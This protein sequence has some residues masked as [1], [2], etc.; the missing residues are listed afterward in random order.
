MFK[1]L[2]YFK[3]HR[4]KSLLAPLFKMT[5]AV[6]ELFVPLV[7]ARIIDEGITAGEEQVVYRGCLLLVLLAVL[8]LAAALLA[9]YFASMAAVGF[10]AQVREALFAKVLR[11]PAAE[12]GRLGSNRLITLLSGDIER[13]Q[14]GVNMALRL[15]MR[16]PVVVFGA[17]VMAFITD[18]RG[19][20]STGWIFA[21]AV[22]LLTVAVVLVM[23]KSIRYYKTAREDV[24]EFTL[25]LR[26]SLTGMRVFRSFGQEDARKD[27]MRGSN[28]KSAK[29][30][31]RA[32]AISA[33]TGPVTMVIVNLGV[34]LLLRYGALRV[35]SGLLTT[36]QL[37][38]LFNYMSQILVELIKLVNLIVTV[39]KCL[40]SADRIAEVLEKDGA[41]E[42][43]ENAVSAC[44][45][46]LCFRNVGMVYPDGT[47]ALSDVSFTLPE[48][49]SLGIIGGTGAGKSTAALLA[50]RF[51]DPTSGEISFDGK[52]LRSY[53]ER[54]YRAMIGMVPQKAELFSG[55]VRDNL[56]WGNP[57][58]SEEELTDALKAAQAYDFVSEKDGGLDAPVEPFGRNFSGGQ[59][60]RLTVARA[61][62][63]KPRL[64]ILDDSASALDYATE[65]AMRQAISDLPYRPTLM[66]ISQ[67]ASSVMHLD[68][69]LVIDNGRAVSC[70]G[71][72]TLLRDCP[73]YREIYESQFGGQSDA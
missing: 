21:A 67:R 20:G 23:A 4:L 70:A 73:V 62:V 41:M 22:P 1:L 46:G 40:A 31:V 30:A 53:D 2:K 68:K 38:A 8:G 17:V 54:A 11:L 26:E 47:S 43:L 35:E 9:Q 50:A 24:E 45:G 39:A 48:G 72:E 15:F 60:Q 42:R 34:I 44:E 13:V 5:E 12:T 7:V 25:D 16:S 52:D 59:R 58:A 64:L 55:T 32:G 37:V 49:G 27:K 3:K 69:I 51:Y 18:N 65:R 36:G 33:L 19:S 29:S 14:T 61:L 28:K 10:A 56:L 66:V 63:R 57:G 6:I 71:H